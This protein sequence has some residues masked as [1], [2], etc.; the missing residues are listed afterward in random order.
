MRWSDFE[1]KGKVYSLS[2]L[3]PFACAYPHPSGDGTFCNVLV[4]FSMHCFTR[5]SLDGEIYDNNLEY[6][7]NREKR[8]FDFYRHELSFNLPDAI[9]E[10]NSKKCF[11]T[12]KG[13]F[14]TVELVDNGG[15]VVEYEIF[16]DIHKVKKGNNGLA[17]QIQTAFVRSNDYKTSMPKKR[18]IK[19]KVIIGKRLMNKKI[20]AQ[21]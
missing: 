7:D 3:H 6:E 15:G 2:H 8:V 13:N 9:K 4:R 5:S 10:L 20:T 14:F 21:K 17:L 12:N 1:Y 19:L 16:F 11:H 18:N